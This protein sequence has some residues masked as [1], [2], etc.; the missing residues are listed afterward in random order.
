[1]V[2]TTKDMEAK[3]MEDMVATKDMEVITK[4]LEDME[5]KVDMVATINLDSD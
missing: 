2:D 1:M 3:D 5:D 4:V